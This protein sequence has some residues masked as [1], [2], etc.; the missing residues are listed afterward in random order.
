MTAAGVQELVVALMTV[1]GPRSISA[2]DHRKLH[3]SLV[4]LDSCS[5]GE[6]KSVPLRLSPDPD[7]GIRVHGVT[8][9]LWSLVH[10]GV[11]SVSHIDYSP[12]FVVNDD[13]LPSSTALAA[14]FS[15]RVW[16]NIH[17]AAQR[18]ATSDTSANIDRQLASSST[19][20]HLANDP[21]FRQ[22]WFSEGFHSAV[23]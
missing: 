20:T 18:W 16:H 22:L 21:I 2:T 17:L 9:A 1:G 11:L 5:S 4:Y 3:E 12:W 8:K 13:R 23:N 15:R 6:G 19:E 7:V 10:E 14:L